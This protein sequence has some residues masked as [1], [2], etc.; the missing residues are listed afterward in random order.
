MKCKEASV[1]GQT[2][3]V[4]SV[5]PYNI[6]EKDPKKDTNDTLKVFDFTSCTDN[7]ITQKFNFQLKSTSHS[8]FYVF[9]SVTAFLYSFAVLV[10]FVFFELDITQ[11]GADRHQILYY[12]I[13]MAMSAFFAVFGFFSWC[14][15]V[16]VSSTF[17]YYSKVENFKTIL[18]KI[19]IGETACT[20]TNKSERSSMTASIMFQ[21]V[22]IG[23]WTFSLYMMWK[24]QVWKP[25]ASIPYDQDPA[26]TQNYGSGVGGNDYDYTY[27]S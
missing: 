27:Q 2:F 22:H 3:D 1:P 18:D 7:G 14:A 26:A 12:M 25:V 19:C 4:E 23:I 5:Y 13:D 21:I 17:S 8:K 15:Y 10:Y 24:D 16:S 6:Y 9:M 20:V 11:P